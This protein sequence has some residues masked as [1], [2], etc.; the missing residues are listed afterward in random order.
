MKVMSDPATS[1]SPARS[2]P[3][4]LGGPLTQLSWIG[5][6]RAAAAWKRLGIET[7]GEL[8][9]HVPSR[10]VWEAAESN[11]GDL[12]P[13]AIGTTRGV[14]VAT[15]C[16]P[17]YGK[18]GKARFEA[19]LDDG[20]RKML[21]TW[22]NALYLR[23][24]IH[25]GMTVHVHGKVGSYSGQPQMINP[26]WQRLDDQ[27]AAPLRNQRL[28]PIYPATEDLPSPLIDRVID[29]ALDLALP[30]LTDPLPADMRER[31][32]LP[33]LAEAYRMLHRPTDEDQPPA[34]RRRLAFNELLLL[35]LGI[36]MKRRFT[37]T[38]LAATPLRFTTAIDQHIR[39][40]FPF[41]L[42]AA[43][44]RVVTEIAADL[45]RDRPMNRL[46]QGDVGS[47]KTVV[48]LY[49]LLLAVA[50]RR[51]GALMAPTELLAEQHY[52]S[53]AAMLA[54]SNVRLE[55]MTAGQGAAGSDPRKAQRRR[56]ERGEVDLVVGT[57][58][59]L[60]DKL[61]FK[62]LALVVV[63]EQHRFGVM[64]RATLRQ[65]GE[66]EGDTIAMKKPRVPHSLVMTAT[67]I[68]RTLSLTV[69]GDLDVS[70][71]DQLPPGRTPVATHVLPPDKAEAVYRRVAQRLSAGDQA[72]VV[73]PAIDASGLDAAGHETASQLK[74]VREHAHL[75]QER[76]CAGFRV[77]AVHGR[78]K[79]KTR[80]AI[81]DRFRRGEIHV[82]VATTVIEVGVDVPNASIMVIEH[83]ERFGL[84]QLHQ[85]RGRVGRGTHG[86]DNVCILLAEP[87]TDDA[88]QRLTA[89][90][91]TTD[92]FQIAEADLAIRGIGEFFGTRQHGAPPLRVARI[93]ADMDLLAL[94]RREAQAIVD[95]DPTLH[96]PPWN[97]LR[98][99]LMKQYGE[100]LGLIDVG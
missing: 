92:G 44:E 98:Q 64:Q 27:G 69:F 52:A 54:G 71:I 32:A 80:E 49:A 81:M 25:P 55:L 22:F 60:T 65:R 84:A 3:L 87:R 82:L 10:Y 91:A 100:T 90:A 63:D 89:I 37:Q 78:L 15:R 48:A 19:T 97:A 20:S 13:D 58:A 67:P 77:A 79:R 85:L 66:M 18:R 47:G 9:R 61:K 76:Y 62:D 43:Q 93:P 34:G 88:A 39:A 42:T 45:Q 95:I 99:P 41:P 94:A 1:P 24:N 68:P 14:I 16:V 4:R 35:Q 46:L 2:Q 56:I 70:T 30:L 17:G 53:I 86:R 8:L 57:Q 26:R 51:Q 50:D 96:D 29:T 31:L 36:A 83:A 12:I 11:V 21:L 6:R 72:Y 40:R 38:Q 33:P 74:N 28:R 75:L 23:D 73:V 7:V 5:P 59:L